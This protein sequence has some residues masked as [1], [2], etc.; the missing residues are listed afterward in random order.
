MY[1]YV[2]NY[3]IDWRYCN[4]A[5]LLLAALLL[6]SCGGASS[7]SGNT[8][9]AQSSSQSLV[10]AQTSAFP[11]SVSA[12]LSSRSLSPL[13]SSSHSSSLIV[14]GPLQLSG[15]V[16]YDYVPHNS[17]YIGLNYAA[18]EIR[19]GRGLVVELVDD[20]DNLFAATQTDNFGHYSFNVQQNQLVRV[21]VKAQ[22]QQSTLPTW[23]VKVVD[24]TQKNQLYV[25]AG[26]LASTGNLSSQRNL[27]ALSGWVNDSYQQL[28]VAAPFAIL[29]TIYTGLQ[30]MSDAGHQTNFTPL[31]IGWS[32]QNKPADGDI[33]LGEISTSYFD[34][35][36]IYLLGD[37]NN[38]TDEYDP[39]VILH[40]W[41][42][43][44]EALFSR[45]DSPGGDHSYGDR[46]DFRVAMAEGY[47]NAFAAILLNDPIYRDT[48]GARQTNG[49]FY[50]LR[51]KNHTVRGW[52]AE[53]SIESVLYN[54]YADAIEKSPFELADILT[55]LKS[56]RYANSDAMVSIFLFA[57]M[58]R[59]LKPE[60]APLFN[61]LLQEQNIS[62]TDEYG[63]GES[64]SSGTQN[65]L[66]LYKTLNANGM[67]INVCSTNSYGNF[68]KLGNSQFAKLQITSAGTYKLTARQQG[69]S[70]INS[71][72][73]MIIYSKGNVVM[74]AFGAAANQES[75]S[76][77]L[78]VGTYILE[79]F[80]A[81]VHDELV[82]DES[83][84]C[85]DVSLVRN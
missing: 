48:N 53:A 75:V 17:N 20:K 34:G 84:A 28:R 79:L 64:N 46:L 83:R 35:A 14:A 77:F 73:D 61:R 47:A 3:V 74:S 49:F 16:S 52:Y 67:S 22:L 42:H 82:S 33:S 32:S 85:F 31:S 5:W 10:Q 13:V 43:Y 55:I 71:D 18:T 72:P 12:S 57:Q 24:N 30:R 19:P 66:P 9:L 81:Q 60:H 1:K 76:V 25:M 51:R 80:E 26:T 29:D 54:Y 23:D 65:V 70:L 39:D 58:L 44:V 27:H 69:T 38:D 41:S 78:A 50:D 68:N 11:S 62:V 8:F 37:A 40:E 45:S 7:G 2:D 21:R 56:S 6:T 36:A 4:C 59:E 15:V 63:Q